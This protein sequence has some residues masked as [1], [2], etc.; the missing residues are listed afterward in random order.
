MLSYGAG[1][2]KHLYFLF[3][4]FCKNLWR[5]WIHSLNKNRWAGGMFPSLCLVSGRGI[6]P[7]AFGRLHSSGGG[8]RFHNGLKRMWFRQQVCCELWVGGALSG[9]WKHG[10]KWLRGYKMRELRLEGWEGRGRQSIPVE[11]ERRVNEEPREVVRREKRLQLWKAREKPVEFRHCSIRTEGR[12]WL[13]KMTQECL[14]RNW[15][16]L[17]W[18]GEQIFTHGA[19][20][21][22]VLPH[23]LLPQR[24]EMEEAPRE[25]PVSKPWVF[26]ATSWCSWALEMWLGQI[27]MH[28][29]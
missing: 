25:L 15:V 7:Q 13:Y 2:S 21:S 27:E 24:P 4:S 11:L 20:T 9:D 19:H 28:C 5:W 3:D 6:G 23:Q 1:L 26:L 12:L 29:L 17:S 14:E 22:R 8:I 16:A 10:R 18:S